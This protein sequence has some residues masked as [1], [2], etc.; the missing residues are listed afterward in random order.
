[1]AACELLL[2]VQQSFSSGTLA[3]IGLP[4][5]RFDA[6]MVPGT[7]PK[8]ILAEA[9]PSLLESGIYTIP[10]AAELVCADPRNVRKWVMG[11]GKTQAPLINNELGKEGEK[12]AISFTNLMELR[13]IARF[14]EAGVSIKHIRAI[15]E[16]A[17][18]EINHP[19]P[20]ATNIIFRTDGKK[21]LMEIARK[22]KVNLIDLK[23]KNYEMINVVLSSL[24]EDV[25]FNPKGEAI[26]W[27][28]RPTIAPS[29]VVNPKHSFGR[30]ILKESRIPTETLVQ[31][32]EAEGS[33]ETVA[34]IYDVP[35]KQ[36]R[37]ALRFERNLRAAA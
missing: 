26:S 14:L 37:E 2:S 29:V 31:A 34:D 4:E 6:D 17:K 13:F 7:D 33:I 23:S 19:H 25:K 16:D 1:M 10:E 12:I 18:R 30:P 3:T 27:R 21:I 5:D 24:K 9:N 22:N 28:P 11:H 35:L 36:V 15:L 32:I 20:L 8:P